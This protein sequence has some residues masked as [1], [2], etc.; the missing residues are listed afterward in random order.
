[1][2]A[3]STAAGSLTFADFEQLAEG[4]DTLELLQGELIRVP[5]PKRKHME[6]AHRLYE[7]LRVALESKPPRLGTP[8]IEMG[9]RID[10]DTWLRPDVSV[11]AAGQRGDD[12]FEGAPALAIEIVSESNS[13][14]EMEAKTE[15]FLANGASEVWLIYP[16]AQRA[17][18]YRASGSAERVEELASPLLPNLRV[19]IRDLLA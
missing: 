9:Y 5:P 10:R 13:A 19:P 16:K 7:A 3:M 2:K 11:S 18:I 15:V 17:W 14:A 6:C 12:Y 8:Y 4:T 1:M